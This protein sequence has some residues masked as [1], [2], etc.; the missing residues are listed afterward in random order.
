MVFRNWHSNEDIMVPCVANSGACPLDGEFFQNMTWE[1]AQEL[2]DAMK[3]ER[4]V[5]I[6]AVSARGIEL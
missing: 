3:E 6:A 5:L 1:E 4:E 2:Y